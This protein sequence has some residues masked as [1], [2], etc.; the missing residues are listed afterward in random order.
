MGIVW[1]RVSSH[2]G[3]GCDNGGLGEGRNGGKNS[4][5]AAEDAVES[6]PVTFAQG[7][8]PGLAHRE[9]VRG[10]DLVCLAQDFFD[11]SH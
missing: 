9:A 3:N 10:L 8:A 7:R 11:V 1:R 4:G 5:L 2:A 6:S